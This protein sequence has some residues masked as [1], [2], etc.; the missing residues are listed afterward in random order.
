MSRRIP[1]INRKK[2]I[3]SAAL[4]KRVKPYLMFFGP[5][6]LRWL[7]NIWLPIGKQVVVIG[8]DIQGLEVAEFLVKRGRQVTIVETS[9]ELGKEMFKYLKNPLLDFLSEKGVVMLTDVK[10][11]EV[12]DEGLVITTKEKKRQIIRADNILVAMP[13]KPSTELF[14]EF[15]SKFAEIYLIGD[16]KEPHL[17]QDA[18][19]DGFH[20]GRAV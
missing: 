18:I 5:K 9:G 16:C 19:H 4:H 14:K 2:V 15:E 1:G 17:I 10:Y 8:G 13:P 11:E 7:T 3:T 12:I 6:V 20:I